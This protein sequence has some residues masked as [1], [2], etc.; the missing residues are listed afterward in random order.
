MITI[1]AI[2][3]GTTHNGV[4]VLNADTGAVVFGAI[5]PHA[6]TLCS[7]TNWRMFPGG[8]LAVEM[9]ASY[10]M[11]VGREVFD[12]CLWIGR[13]LHHWHGDIDPHPESL[14]YRR[15]VKL[16][17]CGSTKANDA[18]VRQAIVDIYGGSMKA[19]K[20]TKSDPGPL[21]G[22]KADMWQALGV[23]LTYRARLPHPS[24]EALPTPARL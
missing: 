18:N 13:F 5:L 2:D 11:P 6:A 7:I 9:I 24:K 4:V 21:F 20:G 19:A 16:E 23:A 22:F 8:H 12:T 17:L 14:V 3:P 15:E 10:G 1:V